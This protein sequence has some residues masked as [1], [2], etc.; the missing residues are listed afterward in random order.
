VLCWE[1]QASWPSG[2][3]HGG[4][5]GA[6]SGGVDRPAVLCWEAQ[7]SW[8]SGTLHGGASGAISG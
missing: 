3:L 4:A 7:A 5:S 2:T 6:F 8:P 1:A